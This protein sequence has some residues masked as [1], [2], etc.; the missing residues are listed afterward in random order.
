M[1][2]NDDVVEGTETFRVDVSSS[3][4]DVILGQFPSA[5]VTVDD[6]DGMLQLRSYCRCLLIY[7]PPAPLSDVHVGFSTATYSGAEEDD[8]VSEVC[9]TKGG[10]NQKTFTVMLSA[11][12]VT[13][14]GKDMKPIHVI[15][16]IVLSHPSEGADYSSVALPSVIT[17]S[18]FETGDSVCYEITLKT[19]NILEGDETIRLELTE[20]FVTFTQ[21]TATFTILESVSNSPIHLCKVSIA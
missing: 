18:D 7:T 9:I 13:A 11:T 10:D 16:V 15:M 20:S 19:D 14:T 21:P 3:D 12:G 1:I 5:V 2:E 17:A 6:D 4:R 8:G